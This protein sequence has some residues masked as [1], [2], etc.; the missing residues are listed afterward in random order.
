MGPFL[1]VL[2]ILGGLFYIYGKMFSGGRQGGESFNARR[3][4]SRATSAKSGNGLLMLAAVN[5]AALGYRLALV[6]SA[7]KLNASLVSFIVVVCLLG[8]VI[9]L[10]SE[11]SLGS[12]LIGAVG[13]GASLASAGLQYGV[14]GVVFILVIAMLLLWFLGLVRGFLP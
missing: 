7:A 4:R 14:N 11:H 10:V 5:L 6:G 9:M 13:F 8:G 12:S 1:Q 3:A 2:V